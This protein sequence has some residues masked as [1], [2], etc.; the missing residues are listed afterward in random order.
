MNTGPFGDVPR[1]CPLEAVFRKRGD[2]GI[3]QLLLR[4]EAALLLLARG[5]VRGIVGFR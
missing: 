1:G 5:L 4:Y 3:E 2:C